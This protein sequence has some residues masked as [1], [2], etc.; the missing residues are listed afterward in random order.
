[1]EH[2]AA[3]EL[4]TGIEYSTSNIQLTFIGVVLCLLDVQIGN[5]LLK[6]LS[7]MSCCVYSLF[8]QEKSVISVIVSTVDSDDIQYNLHSFCN[9]E[10][11]L[12]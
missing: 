6:C 8:P 4:C 9:K 10:I 12:L 3:K 11:I 7:D 2:L 1:M 5:C